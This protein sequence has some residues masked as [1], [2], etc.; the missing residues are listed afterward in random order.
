MR[1]VFV[2]VIALLGSSQAVLACTLEGAPD[3]DRHAASN[4]RPA[5]DNK[6]LVAGDAPDSIACMNPPRVLEVQNTLWAP[7]GSQ[8]TSYDVTSNATD[9]GV[10]DGA[11]DAP[12]DAAIYYFGYC[13]GPSG[14]YDVYLTP[15]GSGCYSMDVVTAS[16]CS[17]PTVSI[18]SAQD[19]SSSSAGGTV[20]PGP[21]DVLV[22]SCGDGDGGTEANVCSLPSPG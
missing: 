15:T 11:P 9:A 5:A 21:Q 16:G 13:D 12:A 17:S 19:C 7:G 4:L 6:I 1:H 20:C 10:S 2:G 8:Y 22:I 14:N 18:V 3:T